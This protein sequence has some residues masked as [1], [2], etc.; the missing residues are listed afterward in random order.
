MSKKRNI[1]S[2]LL[3][4]LSLVIYILFFID[5]SS[6]LAPGFEGYSIYLLFLVFLFGYIILWRS[7][8]LAGIIFLVWY[9][10]DLC[11]VK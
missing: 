9:G 6:V 11:L 8:T 1:I 10:L 4:S 5:E 2:L 7:E 3:G